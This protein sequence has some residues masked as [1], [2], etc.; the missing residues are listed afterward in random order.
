[1]AER[2]RPPHPTTAASLGVR[3]SLRDFG[4][5]S[6]SDLVQLASV[7]AGL[8]IGVCQVPLSRSPVPLVRVLPGVAFHLEVWMVMHEDL[9]AQARVRA[10][11][12]LLAACLAD[13]AA[14]PKAS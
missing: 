9:R 13:Y 1:M 12:D 2:R 3:A 6:D 11:F 14:G 8:G 5:R 7:R 4:L 10:V